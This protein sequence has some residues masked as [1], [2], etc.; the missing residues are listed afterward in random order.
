M[1]VPADVLRL[2]ALSVSPLFSRL[3]VPACKVVEPLMLRVSLAL[4]ARVTLALL[5]VRE[6]SVSVDSSYVIV[7]SVPVASIVTV[8]PPAAPGTP[9]GDQFAATLQ[10]PL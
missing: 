10:S 7:Y 2:A 4:S 1:K 6:L 5:I 8:S 3:I 9:F